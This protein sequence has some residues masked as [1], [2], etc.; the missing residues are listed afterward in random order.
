VPPA[1]VTQPGEARDLICQLDPDGVLVLPLRA[2]GRTLGLLS[3]FRG[4][5]RTAARDRELAATAV[6]V[7]E[8]AG[9]ALD[10]ARRY[11][12]QRQLAEALQRSLLTAPPETDDLEVAVRY[13][14]AAEAAEIGGDWYD[15]FLQPDGATV[16]VIG[17]VIGHDTA[18]AVTMGQVR[19]LLRGIAATTGEGPA[20]VLTRLDAAMELLQVDM[21]A[22]VAVVRLER[23]P[24][25]VAAGVTRM[26]WSSAGH[27]PPMAVD[28]DGTAHML[29]PGAGDDEDEAQEA[30]LL[31][32]IDPSTPRTEREVVLPH[33]ATV[34]L[35][36]DG[37][38][39]RRGRFLDEGLEQLRETLA[40][41]S[42]RD[43]ERLCDGVLSGMLPGGAE[44]DVAIAAVRVHPQGRRPRSGR[45][46][47]R[48]AALSAPVVHG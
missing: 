1:D 17:D 18:A 38:V 32:G 37:L 20:G 23:A 31:L 48:R 39:E 22:T 47:P 14:P 44:D 3:V 6:E 19:G 26:R 40:R 41:L 24:E 13:E 12:Q 5:E 11:S 25:D 10:S 36:T 46:G 15:A 28:P 45:R 16:L 4:R 2:R 42:G 9:L 35:Y 8:R 33:G 27:P 29:G 43:L 34:L 30:D 21:P 7:A